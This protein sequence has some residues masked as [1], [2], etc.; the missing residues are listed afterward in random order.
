MFDDALRTLKNLDRQSISISIQ[1]DERGYIDKQC[2]YE[3]CEFLFKVHAEDWTNI[4]RD[5][6]VWC[7]MCRHQAPAKEWFTVEQV[8]H[9]TQQALK[10]V[11]GK[12]HNA[13]VSDAESFNRRQ[14]PDSFIKMSMK[15]SGGRRSTSVIPASAAE[16]MQLEIQCDACQARYAV[17]GSAF[18]CPACGHNSVVRTYTDALTKIQLKRDSQAIIRQA[19]TVASGKDSA[20]IT[21][22]SLLESC[23][24]DGVVAFQRYCESLYSMFGDASFNAFQRLDQGNQ[25]WESAV[26]VGYTNWL[27]AEELSRL[28]ILF[29]KRHLLAHNE[30]IVD[31]RYIA[32]SGDSSYKEGQR[33]VITERDVG[34]LLNCLTK[35]GRALKAACEN[36]QSNTQGD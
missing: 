10:L 20:E 35:L 17:I 25:L 11:K 5:E 27:D 18:F 12:I 16:A 3:D 29:Q 34:D 24:S 8:E 2:P 31:D 1:T 28:K 9:A 21:C 7:P 22:R 15:V 13:L 14:S 33:I 4:F 6:A 36:H 26:G 23:I 19:L 32:K 30:G